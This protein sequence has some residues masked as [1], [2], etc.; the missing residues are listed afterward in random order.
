M[1]ENNILIFI[2]CLLIFWETCNVEKEHHLILDKINT[3]QKT[4]EGD[5][6]ILPFSNRRQHEKGT[7][8]RTNQP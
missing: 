8:R 7:D 5:Q 4:C 1:S 6:I 2:L 3:L